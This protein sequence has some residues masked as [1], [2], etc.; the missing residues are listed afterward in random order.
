MISFCT[1]RIEDSIKPQTYPTPAF[2]SRKLNRY[3]NK[4]IP[5]HTTYCNKKKAYHILLCLVW[6]ISFGIF[7]E[8]LFPNAVP[9]PYLGT[10]G[11]I[12]KSL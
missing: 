7:K 12:H 2:V 9:L 3:Y 6:V 4:F 8:N 1:I 11:D 5:L 10:G